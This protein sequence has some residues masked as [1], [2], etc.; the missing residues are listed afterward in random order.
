MTLHGAKG[1][2]FPVV[3]LCGISEGIVPL[4]DPRTGKIDIEEERRLFYVGLTR[5]RE[6][7]VLTSAGRRMARGGAVEAGPSRF[8]DDIGDGYIVK[9]IFRPEPEARQLSFL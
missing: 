8:I 9:E 5:A 3:F 1:L 7:L 6:E 2:E 4:A